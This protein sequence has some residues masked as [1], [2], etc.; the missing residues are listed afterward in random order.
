MPS[1]VITGPD[2]VARV[3]GSNETGVIATP[4]ASLVAASGDAVTMTGSTSYLAVNGT[5]MTSD[6]GAGNAIALA[7]IRSRIDI[8]PS[9]YLHSFGN[10]VIEGSVS[11]SFSLKNAGVIS[12]H[13]EALR[14]FDDDGALPVTISN[15]GIIRAAAPALNI[16]SGSAQVTITNTGTILSDSN[17]AIFANSGSGTGAVRLFN[18]GTISGL[19]N[20]LFTSTL[21]ANDNVFNTGTMIGNIMFGAGED[22]YDGPGTLAGILYAGAGSDTLAGGDGSDHFDGDTDADLLV[23]R[24][25]D[26]S[27][28]GDGG[29]DTVLGGDGNDR[30]DGG[31]DNDTLNGNAG[32]DTI[33]GGSGNDI[34]VGQDGSDELDGGDG[35]DTMDGGNGDDT[36]EGGA[37]NDILRGRAGEDN[38]AGG[39]GLDLLTGGQ[40]ADSFVFRSVAETVVGAN[41][42]QILDFEQGIDLIVVSG[43]SPGVFEFKGTSAFAPSGNPELRLFETPTGSTIVQLDNNG[44]GAADAEIRVA[45]ITGLTAE[46]FVL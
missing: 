18:S 17:A 43:L 20:S 27:L 23:G 29:A 22:Y 15:S 45:N 30:I 41:R 11:S 36:L 35:L 10:R 31:G 3:L 37:D 40:D 46:D 4:E 24:G 2:T 34:L 8:G 5:L 44:D 28:L 13:L 16:D 39:L 7:S 26:D 9:G 32:D 19:M 38:L 6:L 12:G 14:I 21:D 42:D 25:G 1:F 33:E